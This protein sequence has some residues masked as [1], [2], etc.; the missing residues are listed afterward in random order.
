MLTK[1]LYDPLAYDDHCCSIRSAPLEG[2]CRHWAR[3]FQYSDTKVL[4]LAADGR[5]ILECKRC[6]HRWNAFAHE[7]GQ[8]YVAPTSEW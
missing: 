8:V 4:G 6:Y 3:D 1:S 5:L 2:P 7:F